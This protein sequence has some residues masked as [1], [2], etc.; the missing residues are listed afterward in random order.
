LQAVFPPGDHREAYLSGRPV[1]DDGFIGAFAHTLEHSA[2]TR[3][4]KQSASRQSYCLTSFR[5]ARTPA[6]YPKNGRTLTDDVTDAFLS[7]LTNGRITTDHLGPH[8]DP[9][10]EFPY[11]GPPHA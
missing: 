1:D 2:A 7:I 8:R 5:D 3:T 4:N 9:L 11:V 10:E 6:G